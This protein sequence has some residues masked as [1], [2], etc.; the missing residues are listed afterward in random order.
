M[1]V[2]LFK[3]TPPLQPL[4]LLLPLK[5]PSIYMAGNREKIPVLSIITSYHCHQKQR[6]TQGNSCCFCS[7]MPS[8]RL[9]SPLDLVSCPFQGPMHSL[10]SLTSLEFFIF[11]LYPLEKPVLTVNFILS[12]SF[13]TIKM[14]KSIYTMYINNMHK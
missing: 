1:P 8:G 13:Q 4:Q 14:Y 9:A 3:W 12:C 2:L 7:C 10:S 6:P 11:C 5:S